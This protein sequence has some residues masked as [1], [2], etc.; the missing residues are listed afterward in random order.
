MW[1]FPGTTGSNGLCLEMSP[2]P[3]SPL[4]MFACEITELPFD[5]SYVK[6]RLVSVLG[7]GDS[8]KL[9]QMTAGEPPSNSFGRG[10]HVMR[11]E[12]QNGRIS[13]PTSPTEVVH[14]SKFAGFNQEN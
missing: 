9:R 11:A 7:L 4:A 13:G 14:L 6:V 3:W 10:S 5:L 2:I 1:G 8:A 12:G